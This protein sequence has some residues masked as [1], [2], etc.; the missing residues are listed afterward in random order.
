MSNKSNFY[1][2]LPSN[3]SK[4]FF[5]DNTASCFRN[6]L[7]QPL[8]FEGQWEVALVEMQYPITWPLISG[9]P[10][11]RMGVLF[12]HLDEKGFFKPVKRKA[13]FQ[14]SLR[15]QAAWYTFI[16]AA[17]IK[18][19]DNFK[20][21][22]LL[23]G[24]P[25]YG[26]DNI[27]NGDGELNYC[28][29][30]LSDGYV[31]Q[32]FYALELQVKSI[33]YVEATVPKAYYT[34][35]LNVAQAWARD[36][37]I[38]LHGSSPNVYSN[39]DAAK[40]EKFVGVLAKY[41]SDAAI[42]TL[43]AKVECPFKSL[44]RYKSAEELHNILGLKTYKDPVI[45]EFFG[46]STYSIPPQMKFKTPALYV[47]SDIVDSELVGDVKVPLLRTVPI[48]GQMGDFVHKEFIRPY[49]KPLTRGYINS[50]LI[51]VKDDTGQDMEFIIGKVIC[52]LNFR[53]CGLAV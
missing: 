51:E 13:Q 17:D 24:F 32:I 11:N 41:E 36:I 43:A 46:Q 23:L 31:M 42:V 25:T 48:E 19:R 2:T 38:Y 40:D 49:F 35:P 18:H 29:I 9:N 14:L 20:K 22:D 45:R 34:S 28:Q 21:E 37:Q 52:T 30:A 15:T 47:Y 39:K 16:K 12:E 27:A 53:R 8:E 5:K 44:V 1:V 26:M 7:A 33:D 6:H 50:I 3:G 10:K 4:K